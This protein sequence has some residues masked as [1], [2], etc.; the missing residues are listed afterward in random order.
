MTK[1][2]TVLVLLSLLV[3]QV[4]PAAD[5]TLFDDQDNVIIYKE[6]TYLNGLYNGQTAHMF[7]LYSS[8]CGHCQRFAPTYK[9]YATAVQRWSRVILVTGVDCVYDTP[10]CRKYSVRGYPTIRFFG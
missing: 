8:W 4:F 1:C 2:I 7:L 5:K 10:V 6:D 9:E 3:L